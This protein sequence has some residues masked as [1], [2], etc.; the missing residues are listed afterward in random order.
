MPKKLWPT[1]KNT[2][3]A[4]PPVQAR[5]PHSHLNALTAQTPISTVHNNNPA[6]FNGICQICT[7]SNAIRRNPSTNKVNGNTS[8]NP[9]NQCG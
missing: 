9:C 3:I 8:Q 1:F 5:R 4:R 7:P 2:P 6:I